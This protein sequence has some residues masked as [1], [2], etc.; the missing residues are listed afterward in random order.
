MSNKTTFVKH[1]SKTHF[2]EYIG[3]INRYMLLDRMRSDCDY[4]LG[5]GNRYDP[6]LWA[7]NP[8]DQIQYM[9]W[10]WESFP[11]DG[12]PEWLTM[13]QIEDLEKRMS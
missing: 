5:F 11:D 7:G 13:E 8:A 2:F 10:L 4:W 12:K 6:H 1:M 9:K 3:G